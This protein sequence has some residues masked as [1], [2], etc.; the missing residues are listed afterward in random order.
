MKPTENNRLP[1]QACISTKYKLDIHII[2]VIIKVS[3]SK[4][5]VSL[6]T[7]SQSNTLVNLFLCNISLKSFLW[8]TTP[9]FRIISKSNYKVIAL[10][11]LHR[12]LTQSIQIYLN[13][14]SEIHEILILIRFKV[15]ICL[16]LKTHFTHFLCFCK[17]N[18]KFHNQ[19]YNCETIPT[20]A[21]GK[22]KP[23]VVQG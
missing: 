1:S 18:Q 23:Q 11:L 9:L 17:F 20:N 21:Q 2:M 4:G 8:V 7:K 14:Q 12:L 16:N 13:K 15:K 19:D 3:F 22:W 10:L 5:N 6:N